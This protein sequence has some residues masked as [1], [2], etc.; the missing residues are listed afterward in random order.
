MNK[1]QVEAC[2]KKILSDLEVIKAILRVIPV[3]NVTLTVNSLQYRY[4]MAL[5]K[6]GGSGSAIQVSQ[7]I[8]V[9]RPNASMN[10]NILVNS[11]VIAANKEGKTKVFLLHEKALEV[12][13]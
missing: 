1:F 11:G 4:V 6:L 5:Q 9:S 7:V 3:P 2:F 12:L 10:L 8:G 13:V